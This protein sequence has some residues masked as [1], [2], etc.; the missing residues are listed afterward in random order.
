MPQRGR[1]LADGLA[2]AFEVLCEP[3]R[4]V[5]ALN[6]DSPHLPPSVLESAFSALADHD[7]VVGPCEDGGYFLVGATRMH[8]GLFDPQTTGT[9]SA[10]DAL[11]SQTRRL[12]LSSAVTAG[13][14]DVD[15]PTDLAR[16]ARELATHPERAPRTAVLL[17]DWATAPP[18]SGPPPSDGS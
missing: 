2:S 9:D 18:L 1:G 8:V 6:G 14:Y 10:L 17:A 12:G 7:V 15:M 3:P 16:L 4:R 5:I 11:I 13:H